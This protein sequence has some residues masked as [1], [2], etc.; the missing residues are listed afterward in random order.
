MKHSNLL[1]FLKFTVEILKTMGLTGVQRGKIIYQSLYINM[2][3]ADGKH[4]E[5]ISKFSEGTSM[6]REGAW[7]NIFITKPC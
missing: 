4:L 2:K 7:G 1:I 3:T 5:G 6:S